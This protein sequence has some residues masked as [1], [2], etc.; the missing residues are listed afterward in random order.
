MNSAPNSIGASKAGSRWVKIRP[1]MRSRASSVK[2]DRPECPSE[3]AAARPAAPAPITITSGSRTIDMPGPEQR[4]FAAHLRVV[5]AS[6][7]AATGTP[8]NSDDYAAFFFGTMAPFLRA[9]ER[10]IAIACLRLVTLPPLP[11]RPE[12]RVPRFLRRRALATVFPAALLYLRPRDFFL[13]A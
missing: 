7:A 6:D 3:A 11:P 10:P 5:I 8:T 12:R 4:A 13:A 9:S 1:P 2:T